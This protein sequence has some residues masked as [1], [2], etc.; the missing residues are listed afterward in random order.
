[1]H[2]NEGK[3]YKVYSNLVPVNMQC[4]IECTFLCLIKMLGGDGMA[5][6]CGHAFMFLSVAIKAVEWTST[7]NIS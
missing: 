3:P 4:I 6:L 5:C 1:M 2:Q 7:R